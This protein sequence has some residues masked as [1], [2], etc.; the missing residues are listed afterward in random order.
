[1]DRHNVTEESENQTCQNGHYPSSLT[2]PNAMTYLACDVCD[3]MRGD[4][5]H[6]DD[7]RDVSFDFELI[8]RLLGMSVVLDDVC[9]I[10]ITFDVLC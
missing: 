2:S 3:R 4:L 8:E 1:M 10:P 7:L 6:I 5:F 9:A